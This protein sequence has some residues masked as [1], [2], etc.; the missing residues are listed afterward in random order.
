MVWRSKRTKQG[1]RD[2]E[3]EFKAQ[4]DPKMRVTLPRVRC[5]EEEELPECEGS[6]SCAS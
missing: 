6:G 5:L 3:R 2:Q 4:R 1:W